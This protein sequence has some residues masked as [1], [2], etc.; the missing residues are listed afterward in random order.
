MKSEPV[1]AN[2]AEKENGCNAAPAIDLTTSHSLLTPKA[3]SHSCLC[4]L[5]WSHTLHCYC[6]RW[7]DGT[8]SHNLLR[9]NFLEV[10][11][12]E[13]T[14]LKTLMSGTGHVAERIVSQERK[15]LLDWMRSDNSRGLSCGWVN[16]TKPG[17]WGHGHYYNKS[18]HF[19][20]YYK[21]E[22]YQQ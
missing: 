19:D 14:G 15:C 13:D 2:I 7:E 20:P 17:R 18:T 6:T 10:T 8:E 3:S 11:G 5:W 4:T 21:D 22:H 9:E 16:W 12:E 1:K